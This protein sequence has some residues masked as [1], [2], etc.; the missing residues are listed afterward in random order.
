MSYQ[1]K[2]NIEPTLKCL[3]GSACGSFIKNKKIIQKFKETRDLSYICQDELGKACFQH[4][5]AYRDFKDLP[6]R[7]A[8]DKALNKTLIP[9]GIDVPWMF[10][11]GPLKVQTRGT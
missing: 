10:P 2:S 9:T 6:G 7:T 8:S 4:N 5:I 11:E 3:L 1:P